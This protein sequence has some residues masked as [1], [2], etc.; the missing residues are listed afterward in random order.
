[1]IEDA[2]KLNGEIHDVYFVLKGT[3]SSSN[4]YIINLDYVRFNSELILNANERIEAEEFNDKSSGIVNDGSNIGGV[5][6]NSWTAYKNIKFDG[7]E[8]TFE[9]RY[10]GQIMLKLMFILIAWIVPQLQ[11]LLFLQREQTGVV[12]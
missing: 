9:I 2:S 4:P 3:T 8:N 12:M 7:S 10:A 1:M 11:Q 5:T 6:N